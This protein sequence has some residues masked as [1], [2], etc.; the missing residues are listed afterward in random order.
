MRIITSLFMVVIGHLLI[1]QSRF[2]VRGTVLDTAG[3]PMEM[4]SLAL[5]DPNDST[6]LHFGLT[7]QSGKF[8]IEDVPQGTYI[9][10]SSFIGYGTLH[11]FLNLRPNGDSPD[12][13]TLLMA[14]QMNMLS[15][16][17]V[18]GQRIP[19]IINK[20][21][22]EYDASAFQVRADETVEDLLRKLPGIEVDVNG[23]ITAQGQEVKKVLVDGKEFFGGNTQLVTKNLPADA[24]KNVKVYDR[25]S[26]NAMYTGVDDGKREKTMD[27]ELKE[28]RKK[29]VFGDVEGGV[30]TDEH[31][32]AKAGIHGF[33][34][35]GRISLLAN[36]NDLNEFGFDWGDYQS[37][38]GAQPG[39]GMMITWNSNSSTLPM[40]FMGPNSG[41][42]LS[43]TGGLNV[44]LFPSKKHTLNFNYFLTYTDLDQRSNTQAQEFN[45][46]QVANSTENFVQNEIRRRH[47]G[48]LSYRWD[49]DSANRV[50][51][52]G[53]ISL[54][55]RSND[56]YNF[57]QKTV[58][59][60]GVIQLYQRDMTTDYSGLR[61]NLNGQYLHRFSKKG[62]NLN[63]S[64]ISSQQDIEQE[65]IYDSQFALPLAGTVDSLD[66]IR[67]ELIPVNEWTTGI[68]YTEPLAQNHFLTFSADLAQY[69]EL[70]DRRVNQ[71]SSGILLDSLSPRVDM[72]RQ[73]Q[74]GS[75]QYQYTKGEDNFSATVYYVGYTQS[76]NSERVGISVDEKRWNYILGGL[77]WQREYTNF[78][79]IYL[80]AGT[81][82]NLPS[83]SQWIVNPDV[84]NPVSIRLGNPQLDPALSYDLYANWYKYD[85]FTK[86]YLSVSMDASYTQDN[87]VQG[88]FIDSNF[89][90]VIQPVNFKDAWDASVNARYRFPVKKI[91]MFVGVGGRL[92]Y[93][94]AFV[95]ITGQENLQQNTSS[96]I[97]WSLRN[98]KQGKFD[99]DIE[100]DY[101]WTFAQYSLQPSLNQTYFQ[102]DYGARV[103]WRPNARW[104][105]RTRVSYLIQSATTFADATA[106]PLWNASVTYSVLEN[107]N[108]LFRVE[109]FDLLQQ[110]T[111]YTRTSEANYIQ[112]VQ[113]NTITRYFL[114]SIIWKFRRQ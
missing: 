31:F 67:N 112:Q 14:P 114:G 82:V 89:R 34:D 43:G 23:V 110:N 12:L 76:A 113:T 107:N 58:D 111:G 17:V 93:N 62:R 5:L 108:L 77:S 85:G 46:D 88:Q 99:F 80:Y 86:T 91:G 102:Q 100:G 60:Q 26:E 65:D 4:V 10:Q 36:V 74:K 8:I 16:V 27:L 69:H 90:R 37:M 59:D 1:A 18:N 56:Q 22:V 51:I 55:D 19:V 45:N 32:K 75:I 94:Q 72:D 98:Y 2:D 11:R 57:S 63:L 3:T 78:G 104:T 96:R 48:Y 35:K 40:S 68:S 41:E 9:F 44:N 66:Q 84:S 15:E 101:T 6:L 13:G 64:F 20:D 83:L 21:T 39:R 97:G 49:P 53:N 29:G 24:V 87:V 81:N 7:D 54:E 25:K 106:V 103:N 42:F 61:W 33:S 52:A 28:D 30:G 95:P 50:E 71:A 109:A 105:L 73:T 79:R 70:N 38:I 92:G 47:Q